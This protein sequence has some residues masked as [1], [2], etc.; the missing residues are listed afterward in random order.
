MSQRH[1]EPDFVTQ[2]RQPPP[3]CCHTC[4]MYGTDGLCT[5]FFM[6]PPEDF[7]ATKNACDK[8]LIEIPL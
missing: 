7:A 3:R 1:P 2:W 5:E 6:T 8:W 4:E